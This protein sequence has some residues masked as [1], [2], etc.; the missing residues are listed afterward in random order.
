MWFLIL[1]DDREN[2]RCP[3]RQ[4]EF[5]RVI[6]L[7]FR[8]P[9]PTLSAGAER[10]PRPRRLYEHPRRFSRGRRHSSARVAPCP[11]PSAL[12]PKRLPAFADTAAAL[13]RISHIRGPVSTIS[14]II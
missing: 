1:Q 2:P 11:S 14:V 9:A 10:R 6:H 7:P 13:W 12:R 5:A 8:S 4:R 3:K